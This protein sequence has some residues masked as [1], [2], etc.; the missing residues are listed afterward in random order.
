VRYEARVDAESRFIYA[1]DKLEPMLNNYLDGGRTWQRDGVTLDMIVGK[2]TQKVASDDTVREL[3]ETLLV[4][5]REQEGVLFGPP[6][7]EHPAP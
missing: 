1:L 2:K 7:A 4:R 6:E 5:L 3:F